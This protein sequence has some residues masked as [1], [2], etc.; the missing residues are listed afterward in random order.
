MKLF[1]TTTISMTLALTV[2]WMGGF[3]RPLFHTVEAF[4]TGSRARAMMTTTTARRVVATRRLCS[5]S[6]TAS[7]TSHHQPADQN[8]PTSSTKNK[9]NNSN[10]PSPVAPLYRS[11]GI[12]AVDKPVEWTSHDVVAYLRGMLERDARSRGAIPQRPGRRNKRSVIK[13]GHGGTLD[14][15]ATG[16]L[17]IGV[18]SGTKE[19]QSYLQGSKRYR[20]GLELGFETATLDLEGNVTKTAP[21][22][23]VTLES[24]QSVV[25]NFVGTL[26]QIPPVFSRCTR[27][28]K[29]L[30]VKWPP[31]LV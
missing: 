20:A 3:T 6:S 13:V 18:G 31:C 11:E 24:M 21:F 8:R 12:F 2:V 5:S 22:D 29:M 15:L 28:S 30:T 7:S 27:S 23:H 9:S 4:G 16:V 10:N 14:P 26:E 19:L 1:R 25:P 17:V